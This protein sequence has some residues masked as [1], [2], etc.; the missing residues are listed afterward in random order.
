MLRLSRGASRASDVL[1]FSCV[2]APS[3]VI[4]LIADAIAEEHT[5][6]FDES[7]FLKCDGNHGGRTIGTD[8]G[9]I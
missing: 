3:V 4:G 1:S 7:G 6:T 5:S 8:G 9:R 2:D